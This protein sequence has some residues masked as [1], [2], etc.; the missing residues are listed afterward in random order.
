MSMMDWIQQN[1]A[2]FWMFMVLPALLIGALFL[3]ALFGYLPWINFLVLLYKP[4]LVSLG[5]VI[6]YWA[7]IALFPYAHPD[8]VV[9]SGTPETG[10]AWQQAEATA[11]GSTNI[12]R[13]IIMG[14]V[15]LAIA[16]AL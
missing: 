10:D 7:D 15:T 9:N 12:R 4:A 11:F 5:P 6:G 8:K 16:L 3:F 2:R 14:S 13:A 1:L